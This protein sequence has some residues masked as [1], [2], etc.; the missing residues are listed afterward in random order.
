MFRRVWIELC[1]YIEL[2][3]GTMSVIVGVV[4]RGGVGII[5]GLGWNFSE[6]QERFL[7]AVLLLLTGFKFGSSRSGS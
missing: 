5:G 4:I 3:F 2:T 7:S 6:G 1:N